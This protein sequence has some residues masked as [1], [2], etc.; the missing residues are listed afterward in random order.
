MGGSPKETKIVGVEENGVNVM[1]GKRSGRCCVRLLG[2]SR[3]AESCPGG[4]REYGKETR[5]GLGSRGY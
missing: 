2:V 5:Q 1:R 3:G 4:S